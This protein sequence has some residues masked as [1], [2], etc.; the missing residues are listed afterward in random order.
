MGTD[1]KDCILVEEKN[2]KKSYLINTKEIIIMPNWVKT[3]LTFNGSKEDIE[4]IKQ[5]CKSDDSEF[6]FRKI[7]PYPE[8]WNCPDKYFIHKDEIVEETWTN[9]NGEKEI[10]LSCPTRHI[11]V[12]S[13]KPWLDWYEWHREF[14]GTKWDASDPIL[15]DDGVWFD[16][17]WSFAEPVVIALSKKFPTVEILFEY[18][19]EDMGNNCASGAVI[20]GA[21]SYD[22][23]E[24][25]MKLAIDVWDDAENWELVDGEWKYKD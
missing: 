21:I 5:F 12:T 8:Y 3:H 25:P 20:A 19:D 23:I 9:S 17:A 24:D 10:H 4:A 22:D 13:D 7:I 15:V 11:T 1:V 14:W 2:S 18:A 6:D 16:T